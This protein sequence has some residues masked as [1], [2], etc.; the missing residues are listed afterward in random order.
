[1]LGVAG[2]PPPQKPRVSRQVL[3]AGVCLLPP[4]RGQ[5]KQ[6]ASDFADEN[7]KLFIYFGSQF[8]SSLKS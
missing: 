2:A 6:E 1:M 3:W 4:S 7:I 5:E 8:D